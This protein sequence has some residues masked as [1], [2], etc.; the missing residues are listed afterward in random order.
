MMRAAGIGAALLGLLPQSAG[1]ADALV[2]YVVEG[3]AIA[4]PLAGL[5]GDA[6]EG[7]RLM[8]DRQRSLCVLC[9]SGPFPDPHLHGTLAPGLAGVGSRLSEGQIRLRI[10]D[11][12][13]LNPESIMP[14][15][16]G[17]VAGE[18][19]GAAWRGR[20]LLDAGEIE[21]LVAYLATL[22]D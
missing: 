2:S 18:R 8:A 6:A 3:D 12:R 1:A 19:V 5:R 15:Y 10:V 20:P 4:L 11:M 22:R 9:H 7:A 16:H 21:H 14:V 13:R 17:G